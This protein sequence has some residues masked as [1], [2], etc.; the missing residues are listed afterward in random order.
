MTVRS[1]V[2]ILAAEARPALPSLQITRRGILSRS[3]WVL[4]GCLVAACGHKA[5]IYPPEFVVPRAIEDLRLTV[6]DSGIELRWG[7]PETYA[8]GRSIDDLGGFVVLRAV[9][10]KDGRLGEFSPLATISGEDGTRFRQT[11]RFRF[12][13]KQ[14]KA[15]TRYQYRIQA[16]TLDGDYSI[17][18]NMVQHVWQVGS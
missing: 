10:P 6:G 9:Q 7:R 4:T 2:A 11:Q 17:P 15:G 13:D 18:S 8:D 14:L 1:A 16:F 12:T 5:P 3:V